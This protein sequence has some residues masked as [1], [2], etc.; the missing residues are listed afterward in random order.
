ME[1]QKTQISQYNI[2]KN[3]YPNFRIYSKVTVFK[4]VWYWWK[5]KQIDTDPQRDMQKT[6]ENATNWEMC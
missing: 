6:T 3:N 5:D 4:T 2:E 1:R